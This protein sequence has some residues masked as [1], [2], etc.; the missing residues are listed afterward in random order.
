MP[1]RRPD[2]RAADQRAVVKRLIAAAEKWASIRA[3]NAAKAARFGMVGETAAAREDAA[4]DAYAAACD[5]ALARF[6]EQP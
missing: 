6:A 4:H 1:S 2:T 3:R 5:A